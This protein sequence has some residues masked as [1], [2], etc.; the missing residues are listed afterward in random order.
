MKEFEK[1]ALELTKGVMDDFYA[2]LTAKEVEWTKYN[3]RIFRAIEKQLGEVYLKDVMKCLDDGECYGQMSLERNP[4]IKAEEENGGSFDHVLID[5]Y[6]NGGMS[7]D[8]FSGYLYIPLKRGLYL[9]C[10]YSM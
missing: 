4:K 1:E 6:E 8:S 3:Q 5:Q 2:A 10:H 7:G 9:K